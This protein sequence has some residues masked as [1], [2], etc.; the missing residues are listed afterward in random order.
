MAKEGIAHF[1]EGVGLF[2]GVTA[3]SLCAFSPRQRKAIIE[4]DS[5]KCQMPN[6]HKHG[7]GLEVHHLLP[8][9]YCEALGINPDFA[10]NAFLIFSDILTI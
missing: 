9:R 6:H 2:I 4:R 5:F 1:L 8:Q 7:G 10:E 3:I